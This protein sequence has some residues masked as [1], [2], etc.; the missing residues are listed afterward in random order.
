MAKTSIDSMEIA[1]PLERLS[2]LMR[3]G[4]HEAGLN[5]AQ[6]EALRFLSRANR[7]SNSA[8]SSTDISSAT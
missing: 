7:V 2:R 8:H 3:G 6:W 4:E 5:P 1:G